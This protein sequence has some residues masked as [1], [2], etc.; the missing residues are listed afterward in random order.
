MTWREIRHVIFVRILHVT[1]SPRHHNENGKA[2]AAVKSAKSMLK[3][4]ASQHQDEYLALSELRNT[5]RQDVR[6]SPAEIMFGR[7]TR[8]LLP[9]LPKP[10][11]NID[12]NAASARSQLK[13][14]TTNVLVLCSH[15][16]SATGLPGPSEQKIPNHL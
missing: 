4:T 12:L 5:P 3:P 9:T 6:K 16:V 14:I 1:S 7:V 15:C 11:H 2:E 8:S 13:S 10:Y